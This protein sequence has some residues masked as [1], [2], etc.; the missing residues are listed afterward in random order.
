MPY[1]KPRRSGRLH[2]ELPILLMGSD[3]EGRVFSEESKTVVLSYHGAGIVSRNK[4]VPEQILS[5]RCLSTGRGTE[6]RVV[7]AIDVESPVHTYG[8]AFLDPCLDFW[9]IEFPPPPS[10]AEPSRTVDIL[11]SGCSTPAEIENGSF[12]FDVCMIHGGLVRF[13]DSCGFATVWRISTQIISPRPRPKPAPPA[14]AEA[15]APV[16]SHAT[17]PDLVTSESRIALLE[18]APPKPRHSPAVAPSS[19]PDASHTRQVLADYSPVE[20]VN[21][22]QHVRAKVNYHA[23]VRSDEFGTDIVA[24]NDMSRGGLSFRTSHLYPLGV[25]VDVAV[26]FS[27]ETPQAPAIFVPARVVSLRPVPNSELLRCGVAFLPRR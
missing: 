17:D 24:C 5:L 16:A 27:R 14:P 7:G 19:R 3:S 2:Q 11:C 22:R 8:V 25:V 13:C 12:E 6:V 20:Q 21:R 26:P 23:C 18:L 9:E 1:S 15:A 4:L 10:N